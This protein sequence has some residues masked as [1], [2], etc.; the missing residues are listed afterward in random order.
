[1]YIATTT[2][3]YHN[4]LSII[5]SMSYHTTLTFPMIIVDL[6]LYIIKLLHRSVSSCSSSCIW[7]LRV[8]MDSTSLLFLA[9]TAEVHRDTDISEMIY[10]T[11]TGCIDIGWGVPSNVGKRLY[12][13]HYIQPFVQG[14]LNMSSKRFI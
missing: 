11:S 10:I 2:L 5:Y 9:L 13:H 12:V 4:H 8:F 14:Q 7:F 1:M 3:L 6:S